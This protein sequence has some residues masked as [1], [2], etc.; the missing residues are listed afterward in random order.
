MIRHMRQAVLGGII[1]AATLAWSASPGQAVSMSCVG[2]GDVS[3]LGL[4]GCDLG[5]LHFD[6]F[7]V[8]AQGQH[9]FEAA[10]FIAAAPFTNVT[11]E[12]TSGG[13]A[14]LAFQV[15]HTID[16]LTGKAP[17]LGD[18]LLSYRASTISG[19]I[20]LGGISLANGG[21]GPVSIHE[22]ACKTAFTIL[23]ACSQLLA[24]L[25]VP[26]NG[27]EEIRFTPDA[28]VREIFIL[29]D[30]LLNKDGFISDFSN[31]HEL[32][33]LTP[34][35]EPGTLLLLGSTF[36]GLTAYARR[37]RTRGATAGLS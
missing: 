3:L 28:D 34:V 31:S 32:G 12:Q 37:K 21:V 15:A 8:S 6:Q 7:A 2:A 13:Q 11:A 33:A 22:R 24:D 14:T 19:D 23:G 26:A 30:I 18:I 5:P 9:N 20:L 27:F 29:K 1:L 35:P 4:A 36:A 10:V 25:V 16:P 17:G